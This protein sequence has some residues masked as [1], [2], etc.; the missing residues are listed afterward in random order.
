MTGA[1]G[2]ADRLGKTL[3][4]RVLRIL[5]GPLADAC[6]PI[7]ERL[8]FD[9]RKRRRE[10]SAELDVRVAV[11]A[12]SAGA[13]VGFV[14]D[15]RHDFAVADMRDEHDGKLVGFRCDGALHLSCKLRV[16]SQAPSA[17][18]RA[19]IPPRNLPS[20]S[21]KKIDRSEN[22]APSASAFSMSGSMVGIA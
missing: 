5:T 11:E 13:F 17:I 12:F 16:P 7:V 10:K 6:A 15:A 9:G 22:D 3:R 18:P 21:S 2:I 14:K 4:A 19:P 1:S 20:S 8:A